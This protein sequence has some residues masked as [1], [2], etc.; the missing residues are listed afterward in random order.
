MTHLT[1]HEWGRVG[2]HNGSGQVPE[3]AFTRSEANAILTAARSHPLANRA[4]TNILVDRY[5]EISTQQVVGVI[6]APGCSLEI[7]PKIDAEASEDDETVR[8]RLVAMLDVALGLKLGDGQA[9]AM[10]RQKDT[11]LDILIRLFADRL[12]VEARRGLPRAYLAQHQDLSALRGRLDI[13]RQFTHHAVR[14]DRLACRFDSLMP[15][16]PL[17][18]IMKACVLMLRR[19][20][21]AIETQRRLDEL[22]FLLAEVS[23]VP[24]GALPW[25]W[26]RIDRTS[27]RWETL[28]RMAKLF[29]KREWQRTNHDARGGQGITLLFAMNDLFEAYIAA[30]ALRASR[31][32]ELTVHAQG[33]LLYCLIEE[34]YGG[35][36]R[37][38]T[39]PDIL[40]KRDG[41]TVMVIDTK[42]KRIGRNPE[43]AKRGVSQA[44]V[45]QM[46]AYARLYRCPEVMLLYPHHVGLGAEALDAAYGMLEGNER[47]RIASVDLVLGEAAVVERLAGLILPA[48]VRRMATG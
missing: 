39:T 5:N 16:T 8:T 23:D 40:I 3:R 20:A 43:D 18:R 33:G 31:S 21:R 6:A 24:V 26:V 2:V 45:Y 36:R 41:Q 38:Q 37:F 47:L 48:M 9:L 42:W 4:G 17:L 11:L 28:Y 10:A 14:Q 46:M 12:L 19:H 32:S 34:G 35:R 25:A 29:L 22:R 1:I 15:D 27:R 44:D 30:L 7:L 13:I